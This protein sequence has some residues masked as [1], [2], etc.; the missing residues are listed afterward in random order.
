MLK[1]L[2]H[3]VIFMFLFGYNVFFMYLCTVF[4]T[5]DVY[6]YNSKAM[7][8]D[9][10][11][12]RIK[13]LEELLHQYTEVSDKAGMSKRTQEETVNRILDKLSKLYKM[14]KK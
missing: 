13:F 6:H 7:P 3:N 10:I 9:P 8:K 5:S 4:K 14:R 12:M 11:E 2:I 1:T